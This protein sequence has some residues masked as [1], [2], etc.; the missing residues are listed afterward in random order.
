MAFLRCEKVI[1]NIMGLRIGFEMLRWKVWHSKNSEETGNSAGIDKFARRN[2]GS[3]QYLGC[4][5]GFTAEAIQ[6][7]CE[8]MALAS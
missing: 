8:D 1:K 4:N 3:P 7:I 6:R 2:A 5:M